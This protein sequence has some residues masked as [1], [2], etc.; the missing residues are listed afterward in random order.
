MF[1]V[2]AKD[3]RRSRS[4]AELRR[5]DNRRLLEI[6]NR[7]FSV[8]AQFRQM[9]SI[10]AERQLYDGIIRRLWS[11]KSALLG[12]RC[13]IPDHDGVTISTGREPMAVGAKRKRAKAPA[14]DCV[15]HLVRWARTGR[16][17]RR[18]GF[19]HGHAKHTTFRRCL[20]FRL[21]C[22]HCMSTQREAYHRAER[23]CEFTCLRNTSQYVAL[24]HKRKKP[25]VVLNGEHIWH[26]LVQGAILE[27][28]GI[29]VIDGQPSISTKSRLLLIGR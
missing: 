15:K 24:L 23:S 12:S 19:F 4:A 7:H 9:S 22:K 8:V 21:L 18:R 25:K 27:L 11:G 26:E 6:P 13:G 28:C 5:R 17:L 29:S 2:R 10:G 16:D 3:K 1:S 14:A 20:L